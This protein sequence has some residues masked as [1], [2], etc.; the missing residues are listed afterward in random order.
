LAAMK[1]L[2]GLLKLN[3]VLC[4]SVPA[5]QALFGYHDEQLA[6]YRRYNKSNLT[7]KLFQYFEVQK[8]RYFAAIL[9][10]IALLYSCWLRKP[11][12]IGEPG[13]ES[14]V[15]KL[16]KLLLALEA[17]IPLFTGTS[18]IAMATPKRLPG[19]VFSGKGQE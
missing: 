7:R 11:Y 4:I 13:K 6:H 1:K 9:I 12:P 5:L 10:P 15:T 8:C 3:G 18:L 16:L 17:K 14:W 19:T 2:A